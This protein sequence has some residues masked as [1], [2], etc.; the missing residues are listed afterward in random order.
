MGLC[1]SSVLVC[2]LAA[3]L[4]RCRP[5]QHNSTGWLI[6]IHSTMTNHVTTISGFKRLSRGLKATQ[7][8]G[9]VA[10]LTNNAKHSII[11]AGERK[12]WQNPVMESDRGM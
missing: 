8:L 10:P 3:S 1:E 12:Q 6:Y 11:E 7:Q 2:T 9:W 4:K 5:T